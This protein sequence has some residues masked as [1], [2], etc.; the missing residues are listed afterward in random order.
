ML[1]QAQPRCTECRRLADG[2][3]TGYFP[4]QRE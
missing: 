3:E 2:Q 4:E 1:R